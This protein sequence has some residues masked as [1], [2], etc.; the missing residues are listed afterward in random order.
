[1]KKFSSQ[2]DIA[3]KVKALALPGRKE[4]EKAAEGASVRDQMMQIFESVG[5]QE[6]YARFILKDSSGR[7]RR[8][9][10]QHWAKLAPKEDG[11]SGTNIQINIVNYGESENNDSIQLPAASIPDTSI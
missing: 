6:E 3:A 7:N 9:F 8:D 1:M 5:G 11:S 4:I 2:V 10:Y